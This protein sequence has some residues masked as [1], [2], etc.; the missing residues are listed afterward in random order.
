MPVS[1]PV[2]L[3]SDGDGGRPDRL[4]QNLAGNQ[5][6]VHFKEVALTVKRNGDP[7]LAIPIPGFEIVSVDYGRGAQT[8]GTQI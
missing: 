1:K 4:V 8:D 3:W 6:D 7:A 5:A 2:R